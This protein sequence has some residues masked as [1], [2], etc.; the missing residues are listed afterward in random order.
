MP[1]GLCTATT[2]IGPVAA[3]SYN[4]QVYVWEM[5]SGMLIGDFSS[6]LTGADLNH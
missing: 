4:G 5:D 1:E 2:F 6:G 3:C